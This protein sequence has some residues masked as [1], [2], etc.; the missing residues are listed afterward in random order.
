MAEK[1]SEFGGFPGV[2]QPD[3]HPLEPHEEAMVMR[4]VDPDDIDG[5]GAEE[6]LE[7]ARER[8][9]QT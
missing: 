6:V 3:P 7:A 1:P 5:M 2:I 4:W 9:G 8:W